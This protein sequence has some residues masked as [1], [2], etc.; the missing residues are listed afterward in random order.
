MTVLEPGY[1]ESEM[2]AR[3]ANT[4]LMVDTATGVAKMVEAIERE[5]GR[6]V[7][8]AWPWIPL[9]ALLKLL[10]PRFTTPFA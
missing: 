6:A 7:V 5:C 3:T 4:M 2:T 1:I 8:P 10:P 9:V